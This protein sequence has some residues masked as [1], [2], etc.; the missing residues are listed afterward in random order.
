MKA[1]LINSIK[2]RFELFCEDLERQEADER[3]KN[4]ST[5]DD[6]VFFVII[7]DLNNFQS[8]DMMMQSS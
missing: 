4:P 3:D 7:N 6:S 5:G 2:S 8:L 1:D